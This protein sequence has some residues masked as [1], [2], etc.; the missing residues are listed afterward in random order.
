MLVNMYVL[1][2]ISENHG[3]NPYEYC[4]LGDRIFVKHF[5]SFFALARG[6]WDEHDSFIPVSEAY[7]LS[8]V[9]QTV[10][11]AAILADALTI[12]QGNQTILYFQD[13]DYP[14][15]FELPTLHQYF[16]SV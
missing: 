2:I 1:E 16:Q 5:P 6:V 14:L 15:L 8:E 11:C 9:G 13:P 10:T 4:L 12:K 7:F 3:M